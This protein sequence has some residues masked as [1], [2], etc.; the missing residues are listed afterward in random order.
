MRKE[1]DKKRST[2]RVNIEKSSGNVFAD[3]GLKNPEELLTKAQLVQRIS[4]I[5]A[6]RKLTQVQAAKLLGIDQPKVS[7]L[8]K[9]KLDGF[10]IDRLFRC[11]NALGRDVEI[12][13]RP[14][15]QSGAAET[16]VV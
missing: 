6:E 10:S 1:E 4:N 16:R 8:L 7:A 9:G 12:L 13:I 14:A 11:L 5:I 2:A 3:L 15:K